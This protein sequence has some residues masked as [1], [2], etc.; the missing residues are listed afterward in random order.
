V[1]DAPFGNAAFPSAYSA[2]SARAL[3]LTFI[4]DTV[5]FP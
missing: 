4:I 3:L 2:Y 5:M 1:E